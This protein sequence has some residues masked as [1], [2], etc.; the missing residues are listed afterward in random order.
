MPRPALHA[1]LLTVQHQLARRQARAD[2]DPCAQRPNG[3]RIACGAGQGDAD[4]RRV[5]EQRGGDRIVV[6]RA[7]VLGRGKRTSA[8]EHRLAWLVQRDELLDLL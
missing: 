6:A 3:R 4:H 5:G 1:V 8:Y 7:H 2:A